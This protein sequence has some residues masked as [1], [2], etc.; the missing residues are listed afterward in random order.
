V[1]S[2]EFIDG[3]STRVRHVTLA[4]EGEY[5]MVVGEDVNLRVPF[6]GVT[7]DERL[8]GAPRRLRLAGGA[9][10]E[11]RDLVKLEALL[12]AAG[13]RDGRV[14]RMQRHLPVVVLAVV[15]FGILAFAGYRWGLP[16]AA[17][18]GARHLPP[19][20]GRTLSVQTLKLLD[21]R[22][23]LP[24]QLDEARQAALTD[25]FRALRTADGRRPDS[26]L[27][28]RASPQLGANAFTLPDGTIIVLDDLIASM[29]NEPQIL[30]V[31]AHELG[32]VHGRHGLQ[33]LLQSSVVGAFLT[34]YI[35][36]ISQLLAATPAAIVEAH[37]SQELE[38]E[39]DDY[40]ALVLIRNGMSPERLADALGALAK[41]HPASSASSF[42]SSHPST[43]AR[44]RRLRSFSGP[45]APDD[46]HSTRGSERN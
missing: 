9:F 7:V 27:L 30:A 20:I 40:A 36:D 18:V 12:S 8:G 19:A 21:G 28:F 24:S 5:L 35:G 38:Q 29:D 1:L 22:L 13:Y 32:H 14:D 26:E 46:Q 17:T 31:L 44:I 39:A 6:A 4:V 2:A 43:D 3:G 42:L 45:P 11:V 34:F 15:A 33:R 41:R 37:Y 10:C 16:W 23:L 25:E